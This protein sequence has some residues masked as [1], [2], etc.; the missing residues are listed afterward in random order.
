MTNHPG[1]DQAP[2]TTSSL[3]GMHRPLGPCVH[4]EPLARVHAQ[5]LSLGLFWG[6][7][8][9]RPTWSPVWGASHCGRGT[10]G[11]REGLLVACSLLK[12]RGGGCGRRCQGPDGWASREYFRHARSFQLQDCPPRLGALGKSHATGGCRHDI[13]QLQ[14]LPRREGNRHLLKAHAVP[15]TASL[16][17]PYCPLSQGR[18]TRLGEAPRK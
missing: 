5:A 9:L 12:A 11:A 16:G 10:L 6:L 4:T 18:N 1:A 7:A 14:T 2:L 17:V 8:V 13:L 3:P 15:T